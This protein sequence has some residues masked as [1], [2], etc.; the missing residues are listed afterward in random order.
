MFLDL[1]WGGL[2]GQVTYLPFVNG[3]V[4][5]TVKNPDGQL[6]FKHHDTQQ[7]KEH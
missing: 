3:K 5:R 4:V 2:E 7:L 6:I 1:A